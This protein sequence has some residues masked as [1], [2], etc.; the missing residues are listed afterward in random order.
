MQCKSS[1]AERDGCRRDSGKDARRDT[2][3]LSAHAHG[4]C[5]GI[6]FG[7]ITA[8]PPSGWQI[9]GSRERLE[10]RIEKGICHRL[11]LGVSSDR[12]RHDYSSKSRTSSSRSRCGF[13]LRATA[14]NSESCTASRSRTARGRGFVTYSRRQE[15]HITCLQLPQV[16]VVEMRGGP[17]Q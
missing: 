14:T 15:H 1:E 13:T 6:P 2:R 12:F 9:E 10:I 16:S 11:S 4:R 8:G 3:K 17:A 7:G 5:L